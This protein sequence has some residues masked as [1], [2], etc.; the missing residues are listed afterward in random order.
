MIVGIDLGTTNSL[1][2]WITR[3]GRPEI[4]I[5]ERGSRLTPS[6]VYFKNE[7]QVIVGELARSQMLLYPQ[8]TVVRVKRKMGTPFRYSIFGRE[9]TPSE[10]S[11]LIL[12]KLKNYA[13]AYLGREVDQA[14]ITVPA[15]F[16]DNQRQATIRAAYL[17]GMTPVKLLNEPTAAALAYNLHASGENNLLVLDFGGGTFDISLMHFSEGLFEVMATGGSTELGGSDIDDILVRYVVDAVKEAEGIDLSQDPVALQQVYFHVERAKIDLST[18]QE[19]TIVIPYIALSER[20]PVHVRLPLSRER[21]NNLCA[22]IFE[23]VESL[24]EETIERA[25]LTKDW[26]QTIVFV[27]GSSRIPRFREVVQRLFQ[28]IPVTFCDSLNPDEVVALGAAIQAGIIE[29]RIREVELR[30]ILPHSLG[31][32]DDQ[33]NFVPILERGTVY[34]AVASRLFTNTRDDQEEAIVEVLQER[35]GGRLISL[36][37][38]CFRSERKWKR[39]EANLEVVFH[40]DESG[41]LNVSA[42]DLDTGRTE[43]ATITGGL[44]GDGGGIDF[45]ERRGPG[46]EVL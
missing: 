41:V 3:E 4:I 25:H 19:T 34:P 30:D 16:D 43:E 33:G 20:G 21:M 15:Y 8:Q 13:E 44:W 10:I 38:F 9:Y 32:L 24:I 6:V 12:R 11:G 22:Q 17:A 2:A 36:G 5:N 45:P 31:V 18:V 14:V 46:L 1:V 23:R 26:V 37:N 27:G 39:G 35:D 42:V 7:R 29:G 40:L 28:G